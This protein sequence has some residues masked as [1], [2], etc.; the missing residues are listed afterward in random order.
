MIV[1]LEDKE[2]GGSME[3]S[4]LLILKNPLCSLWL[5]FDNTAK[6]LRR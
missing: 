2:G 1:N 4:K 6:T 3:S 5:I